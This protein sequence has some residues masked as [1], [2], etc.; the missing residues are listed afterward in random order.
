MEGTCSGK[1]GFVLAVTSLEPLPKGRIREGGGSAIFDVTYKCLVFKPFRHEV[2]DA[3]VYEVNR[4]SA[5]VCPEDA[6][7]A[8]HGICDKLCALPL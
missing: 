3:V 7:Q 4:V 2:L 6:C 8:C 5:C 1:H